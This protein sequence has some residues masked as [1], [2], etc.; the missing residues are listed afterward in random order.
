MDEVNQIFARSLA[1]MGG[2]TAVNQVQRITAVANCQGPNGEYVTKL[3]SIRGGMLT[4]AQIRPGQ[5]PF[6]AWVANSVGGWIHDE[7]GHKQNLDPR[8]ITMIR[9]HDFQMIALTFGER[10]DGYQSSGQIEF[11]TVPCEAVQYLDEL[12]NPCQ[13]FF[14]VDNGMW[15]GAALAN[16]IGEA[17]E[18]VTIIIN[19]WREIRGIKLP[20]NISAVDKNGEFVLDFTEIHLE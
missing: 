4:F 6:V 18:I 7:A 15:A 10:Y 17:G 14:R 8:A 13:A 5:R 2:E 1:G 11:Q 16:S 19:A 12:G 20:Q 3:D 9:S